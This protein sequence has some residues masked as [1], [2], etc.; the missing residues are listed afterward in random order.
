MEERG[1]DE[2]CLLDVIESGEA[3]YRDAA[4]LW[5]FKD[6]DERSDI[7]YARFWY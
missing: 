5:V 7:C 2:A 6:F 4:H 1:I 3:R